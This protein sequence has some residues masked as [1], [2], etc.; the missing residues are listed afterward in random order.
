MTTYEQTSVDDAG[1]LDRV[2]WEHLPR[3]SRV[4]V[5]IFEGSGSK[6]HKQKG[7]NLE[8]E[9]STLGYLQR[10]GSVDDFFGWTKSCP[11]LT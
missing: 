6:H 9:T 3:R 5:R 2:F 7:W 8:P 11:K 10:L 1:L 4:Q